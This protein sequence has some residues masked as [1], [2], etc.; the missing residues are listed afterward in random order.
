MINNKFKCID[1]H[2]HIYPTKIANLARNH[3]DKFY[4]VKS[5]HGG[6]VEDLIENGCRDGVDKFIVQS[7]ATTPHQVKSINEF[8]KKEVD[9]FPN[10]LVGL[11]TAHPESEDYIGDIDHLISLGLRGI[12]VHPDIQNF[13]ADDSRFMKIFEYMQEKNL[14]LLMH[15]GDSRYDHSNPN[16][17]IP[18][19]KAFPKL[20]V[21]GAHFGGWSIWDTAS[22]ELCNFS[23]FYVDTSSSLAY[24]TERS[25]KEIILRYGID[26]VMFA[27]DYPM[28]GAKDDIQRL[29]NLGFSDSDYEK[30]FYKNAE[31]VFKI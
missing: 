9:L 27:S 24:L 18:I 30:L 31:K 7:V 28:W 5:K 15:A 17:I 29:L 16:R 19:L 12:K 23:N 10:Y 8:I 14:T 2:C 1:S 4:S 6:T 11:G 13:D 22:K 20:T 26:K 3:T 21:V 25:V